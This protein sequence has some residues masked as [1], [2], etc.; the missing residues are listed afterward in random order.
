MIINKSQSDT[1]KLNWPIRSV[2]ATALKGPFSCKYSTAIRAIFEQLF[3]RLGRWQVLSV[4][5]IVFHLVISNISINTDHYPLVKSRTSL[6]AS[7]WS[8]TQW[9]DGAQKWVR[10]APNGKNL[11]TF[12]YQIH[13]ILNLIWEIPNFSHMGPM[14]PTFGPIWWLRSQTAFSESYSVLSSEIVRPDWDKN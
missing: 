1:L 11:G 13:Y 5:P 3:E 9:P 12:S 4:P 8:Q 7:L 2:V 14:W 10:L 6:V